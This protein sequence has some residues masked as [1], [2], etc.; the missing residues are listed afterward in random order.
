LS[1]P[2]AQV[3]SLAEERFFRR[4]MSRTFHGRDVFAPVAAHLGCGTRLEHLGPAVVD[5]VRLARSR[6]ERRDGTLEGTVRFIDRFGNALTNITAETLEDSFPR[7]P[8]AAIVVELGG[9]R[10]TGIARSYGD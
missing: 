1:D 10:I 6:P 8:E 2:P 4:P 3:R 7:V 5:A 9:R